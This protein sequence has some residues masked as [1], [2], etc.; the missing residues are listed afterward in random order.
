M[1]FL[2]KIKIN[3]EDV[4]KFKQYLYFKEL[5]IFVDIGYFMEFMNVIILKELFFFCRVFS[6]IEIV[7]FMYVILYNVIFF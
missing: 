6:I 1:C 2:L 3:V 7:E 5:F 4:G